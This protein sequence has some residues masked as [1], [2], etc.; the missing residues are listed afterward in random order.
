M[1]AVE[2]KVEQVTLDP[3]LGAPVVIL[4]EKEGQ[5]SVPIWVGQ[6]EAAAIISELRRVQFMRPSSHDLMQN[7][8]LSLRSSV[9][10]INV[11]DLKD[12]T[13]FAEVWLRTP[14]GQVSVDSRPSDA[15]ALALRAR[16]PIYVEQEVMERAFREEW[17][18]SVPEMCCKHS[19]QALIDNAPNDIYLEG[20]QDEDFG[21]WK[22]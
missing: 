21:K 13:F 19:P 9:S 2:M 20:L 10:H 8:I 14:E 5:R 11:S 15:I 17:N 18:R 1:A 3:I 4:R 7:M 6:T 12:G 22:M 16:S